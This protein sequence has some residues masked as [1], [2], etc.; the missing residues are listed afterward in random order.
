MSGLQILFA[1]LPRLALAVALAGAVAGCT[2]Y[3][4]VFYGNRRDVAQPGP[5][6][7]QTI[8]VVKAGDSIYSIADQFGTSVEQI[9]ARNSLKPPYRLNTGQW[10]EIPRG[11]FYVVQSG[12]TL[13]RIARQHNTDVATLAQ[14]N[15]IAAPYRI[16]PGDR[17][18]IPGAA[19]AGGPAGGQVAAGGAAGGPT[20]IS[21]SGAVQS[22]A[23]PPPPGAAAAP[24][25][26]TEPPPPPPQ[27][28][29]GAPTQIAP[30]PGAASGQAPA[31]PP[32]QA[33]V[34]APPPPPP[35]AKG[36]VRFDWPLRGPIVLGFGPQGNGVQNDGINIGAA[37]GTPVKAAESGMV[38]YAGEEVKGFGKLV[39]IGHRDGYVTAYGHND[40]LLVEKGRQVAKGEIIARVGQTGNVAQPQLHFEIRQRNK[41]IDPLPLLGP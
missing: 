31:S 16:S 38:V 33:A 15:G 27:P 22:Q 3:D 13:Y 28:G 39:L 23:L 11:E 4:S 20:P 25:P 41:A 7:E 2:L 18:R 6:E 32:Q 1:R 14:A 24:S 40:E 10:L 36:P 26:G 21:G 29:S 34:P 35:P 9:A 17:L 19:P 37:R 5:G 12:D 30:A 8:Y